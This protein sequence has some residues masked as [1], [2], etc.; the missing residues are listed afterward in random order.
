MK[1]SILIRYIVGVN[2]GNVEIKMTRPVATHIT[3]IANGEYKSEMCFWTGT[4][5]VGKD[6]PEPI[7]KKIYVQ[8]KPEMMVYVRY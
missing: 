8:K 3:P 4:P 7:D 5:W 2:K 6:L 1:L